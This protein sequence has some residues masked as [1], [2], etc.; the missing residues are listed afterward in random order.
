M[1]YRHFSIQSGELAERSGHPHFISDINTTT[2][3]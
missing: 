2:L 1:S 3:N